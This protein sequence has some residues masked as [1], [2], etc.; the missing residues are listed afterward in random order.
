MS[1][2]VSFASRDKSQRH[3]KLVINNNK[4][5]RSAG[6]KRRRQTQ[7]KELGSWEKVFNCFPRELDIRFN[8]LCLVSSLCSIKFFR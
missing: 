3:N 7:H 4:T 2:R 5:Y 1:F 8:F 6:T